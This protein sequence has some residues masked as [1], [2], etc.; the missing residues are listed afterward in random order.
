M[1]HLISTSHVLALAQHLLPSQDPF[2]NRTNLSF[3][4]AFVSRSAIWS[5]SGYISQFNL[6]SGYLFFNE[7]ILYINVLSSSCND[8]QL[9][10]EVK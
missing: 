10:L 1:S 9:K 5:V 2:L 3:G 8:E 6:A 4:N 7:V